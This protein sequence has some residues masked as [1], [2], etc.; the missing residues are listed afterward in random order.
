MA[1]VA[2][3]ALDVL[4]L[5]GRTG[6][7]HCAIA[8]QLG[9]DEATVVELVPDPIVLL[10]LACDQVY[11]E[12]DLRPLDLPWSYRLETYATNFRQALLRHPEAAILVATR[13]I[14][15]EASMA[16]AE[17]AL[18]ELTGVGF[19]PAEANRVL[20]VI[21]SFVLGHV[22]VE[23]GVSTE[24][25]RHDPDAVEAFRKNLP[26]DELPLSAEALSEKN[27]RDAEFALGLKL[28]IDGLER[29]VLH[30]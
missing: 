15:S 2:Q 3:S 11:A 28:L 13:P 8:A 17:R 20:L 9:V 25:G 19:D 7:D 1:E 10:D 22:L 27:D 24:P 5:R 30:R 18:A 14:V 29:R 23:I 12:V 4:D 26:A 16:L 6:L 21:T